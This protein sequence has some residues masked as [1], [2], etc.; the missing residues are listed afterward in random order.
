MLSYS[1][2]KYYNLNE[3]TINKEIKWREVGGCGRMILAQTWADCQRGGNKMLLGEF[4]HSI[5]AKGRLIVPAKFRGDLGE[6][7]I[8]TRGLDGCLF[9]Y[10]ADK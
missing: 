9:G 6:R 4:K 8:V 10:P 3:T 2:Y 7:F 1:H 5:D